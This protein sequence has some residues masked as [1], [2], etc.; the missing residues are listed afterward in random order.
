MLFVCERQ[1][2]RTEEVI[3]SR[4]GSSPSRVNGVGCCFFFKMVGRAGRDGVREVH[5][6]FGEDCCFNGLCRVGDL[7]RLVSSLGARK[8]RDMS[9]VTSV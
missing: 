5:L 6:L 1:P 7:V 3:S 4:D 9:R 8:C 2:T